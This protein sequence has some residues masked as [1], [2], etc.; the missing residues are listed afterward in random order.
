MPLCPQPLKCDWQKLLTVPD[1]LFSTSSL[2]KQKQS[3]RVLTGSEF[4]QQLEQKKKE[5]ALRKER[6]RE[7]KAKQRAAIAQRK[8]HEKEKRSQ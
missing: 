4:M 3:G 1:P 5:E 8:A 7:D 6:A 2:T